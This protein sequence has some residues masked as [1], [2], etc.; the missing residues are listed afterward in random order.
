M[1]P[2]I[3]KYLPHVAIFFG[4]LIL[5]VIITGYLSMRAS[6]TYLEVFRSIYSREQL[7]SAAEA[8]RHGN[9]YAEYVYRSNAVDILPIGKLKAIENTKTV[10]TFSFPFAAPGLDRIAAAPDLEKGR[11]ISYGFEL[12]RLADA[13]EDIGL[14]GEAEK[15]WAEAAKL[16][17][18]NDINKIR[19][20]VSSLNK[21]DETN[22]EPPEK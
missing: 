5:G 21:M 19:L 7:E 9:K 4:G 20:V 14:I 1:K 8:R 17:G 13:A 16:T 3:K 18:C 15:L 6:E 12:G 11:S 2:A 10:W 22:I